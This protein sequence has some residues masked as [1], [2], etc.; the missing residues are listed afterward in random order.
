MQSDAG[1]TCVQEEGEQFQLTD[2]EALLFA[3]GLSQKPLQDRRLRL[4]AS[5]VSHHPVLLNL[6][7][8]TCFDSLSTVTEP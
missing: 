4:R 5:D 2:L 7:H 8:Q 6:K 3:A 1:L